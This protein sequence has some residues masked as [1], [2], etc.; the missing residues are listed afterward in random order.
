MGETEP[1]LGGSVVAPPPGLSRPRRSGG[2]DAGGAADRA[3]QVRGWAGS[4][5][6][7]SRASGATPTGATR[8]PSWPRERQGLR[9]PDASRRDHLARPRRPAAQPR[10]SRPGR[11]HGGSARAPRCAPQARHAPR[12][13]NGAA[14]PHPATGATEWLRYVEH[15]RSARRRC[16]ATTV[17]GARAADPAYRRGHAVGKND[18]PRSTAGARRRCRGKAVAAVDP[19]ADTVLHGVLARAKRRGWIAVNPAPMPSGSA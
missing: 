16:S 2:G 18:M 8:P 3:L 14:R 4:A 19:E 9:A 1:P 11:R 15:E 7:H 10:P 13:I 17:V 6:R 5:R 12:G